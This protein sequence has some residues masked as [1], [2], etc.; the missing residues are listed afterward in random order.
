MTIDLFPWYPVLYRADTR[1]LTPEQDGCYRRLIDEYMETRQP[2]PNQHVALARICGVSVEHFEQEIAPSLKGFFRKKN[3]VLHLKRC[4]KLLDEQDGIIRGKSESGKKGAEKRWKNKHKPKKTNDKQDNGE[5][6]GKPIADPMPNDSTRQ[7]KTRQ[8]IMIDK[9]I[10][11][12]KLIDPEN[13][14]SITQKCY[15]DALDI[16]QDY[17]SP[18]MNADSLLKTFYE[19]NTGKKLTSPDKAFIGFVKAQANKLKD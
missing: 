2:L 12:E 6:N 16:C 4:D 1:T 13:V 15:E 11:G 18:T 5:A 7:D 9:S 10:N 8:D 3:G 19:F 17:L 14:N